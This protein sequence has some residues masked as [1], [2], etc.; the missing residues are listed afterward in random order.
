MK[1]IKLL[2]TVKNVNVSSFK[3]Y[4]QSMKSYEKNF[5]KQFRE[6]DKMSLK[7]FIRRILKRYQLGCKTNAGVLTAMVV[8]LFIALLFTNHIFLRIFFWGVW[9]SWGIGR[10]IPQKAYRYLRSLRK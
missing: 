9:F 8:T 4:A 10:E 1:S 5:G 6:G 3:V 2:Q 7:G